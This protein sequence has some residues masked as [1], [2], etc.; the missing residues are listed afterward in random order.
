MHLF[1]RKFFLAFFSAQSAADDE[2]DEL[3]QLGASQDRHADP[4]TRLTSD[5]S[6]KILPLKR[7]YKTT[8]L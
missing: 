8:I 2:V 7:R 6:C 4:Q 5:V 1:F 3:Q